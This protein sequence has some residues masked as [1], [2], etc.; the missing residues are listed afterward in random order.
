MNF[1]DKHSR[2]KIVR[3]IDRLNIGGPS[4]HVVLLTAGMRAF[5]TVLVAGQ[6]DPWEGDMN[7]FAVSHGVV[8]RYLPALR[9][10]ISVWGDLVALWQ[11]IK[12]IYREKPDIVHTHKSKAGAIGRLAAFLLGVPV[13]VHTFH[14][15]VFHGYFG[16]VKSGVF[17]WL[18]RILA[19]IT[20]KI[21]VIGQLQY[22]EICR[23]YRVAPSRK[24]A[25]IPL[26]FDFTP[27]ADIGRH[28]NSLRRQWQIGEGE[29]LV[30]I[31]GRLT[32]VKNH[33]LFLRVAHQVLQQ[34]PS[35]RFA[36]IGDGELKEPLFSLAKSLDIEDRVVFTGWIEEPAE[37][38]G[39]LDIV[40]LTSLNEGTPVT[41][42]EAMF[43]RKPVV[44]TAVGG[45]PDLVAD[46]KSGFLVPGNDPDAFSRALL[47][48]IDNPG[49]RQEMGRVAHDLVSE[50]Y[51]RQRLIQDLEKLYRDPNV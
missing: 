22:R 23:R 13:I 41:I 30:G 12:I 1:P 16:P 39:S 49:A 2:L 9:R 47:A 42:I 15:H 33:A 20:D 35:V 8:P 40:A 17:L 14:G 45:V 19:R 10:E 4:V 31:V 50:K 29:V 44:A 21:V 32:P 36:V 7:Y 51:S 26:G 34:R 27:L 28:G 38:Y 43:C 3:I 25:V 11:I 24:F 18:E 6:I 37:I 46:K 48:L 5:D